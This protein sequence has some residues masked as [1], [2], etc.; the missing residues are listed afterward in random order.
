MNHH[1]VDSLSFIGY[2][3]KTEMSWW[4]IITTK[5]RLL[6][7]V[8]VTYVGGELRVV[9]L[10]LERGEQPAILIDRF[11]NN[12]RLYVSLE[13]CQRLATLH[14]YELVLNRCETSLDIIR[15]FLSRK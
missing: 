13:E 15:G 12:A 1:V 6:Q 8:C 11:N 2:N 7:H 9:G 4:S 5:G 3:H 10:T 14:R